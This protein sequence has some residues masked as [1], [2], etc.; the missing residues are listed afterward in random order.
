M[1]RARICEIEIRFKV[2]GYK[3]VVINWLNVIESVGVIEANDITY[4]FSALK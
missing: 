2:V 4:Y 3:E 1:N